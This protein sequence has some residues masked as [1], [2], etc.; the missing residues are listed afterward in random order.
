MMSVS[1]PQALGQFGRVPVRQAEEHHVVAGEHARLGGLQDARGQRRQV[2]M[3]VGE[4]AAGI[5]RGGERA[6]R[7]PAVGIRR[8]AEQQPQNLAA[9]IPTGPSDRHRRH[10]RDSAW[11]CTLLQIH[12]RASR[13]EIAVRA[14]VGG[15][16]Q[17]WRQFRRPISRATRRR[18]PPPHAPPPRPA[19]R[20]PRPRSACGRPRGNATRAS[21]ICGP[22][23]CYCPVSLGNPNALPIESERK[24]TVAQ[25]L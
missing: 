1:P 17:T 2:G 21:T 8:M 11:L 10:A 22:R 15:I 20:W 24:R 9:G 25:P 3:M 18:P 23:I 16:P 19:P 6:E 7:Q 4:R 14:V 13:G 5:A 12:S